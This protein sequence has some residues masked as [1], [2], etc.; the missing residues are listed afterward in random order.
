MYAQIRIHKQNHQTRGLGARWVNET[1][2]EATLSKCD[3]RECQHM[4]IG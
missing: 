3:D 1:N 4:R 2:R